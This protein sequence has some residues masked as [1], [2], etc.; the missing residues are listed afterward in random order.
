MRCELER[1]ALVFGWRPYNH[2]AWHCWLLP[3]LQSLIMVE[4]KVLVVMNFFKIWLLTLFLS[5]PIISN[6]F[7]RTARSRKFL[8]FSHISPYVFVAM[9]PKIQRQF[10]F[11][12]ISFEFL[13]NF[14]YQ[15][16]L[17]CQTHDDKAEKTLMI[18]LSISW[19]NNGHNIFSH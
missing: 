15:C 8:L 1:K 10:K 18:L 7:W 3:L 9:I 16:W 2:A 12:N 13:C 14:F 19:H 4:D 11:S 5:I 6:H 17:K